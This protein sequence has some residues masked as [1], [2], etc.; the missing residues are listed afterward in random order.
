MNCAHPETKAFLD[1]WVDWF[2]SGAFKSLHEWHDCT[3]LDATLRL[4][5]KDSRITARSLSGEYERDMHPMAKADISKYID[6]CKGARK[7]AGVS[8][9]NKHREHA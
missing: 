5:L 8:P 2:E 3:T 4:F 1:T 6:H 9:E 7:A